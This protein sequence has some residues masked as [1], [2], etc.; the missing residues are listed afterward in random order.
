MPPTAV[1]NPLPWYRRAQAALIDWL[2]ICAL[3]VFVAAVTIGVNLLLHGTIAPEMREWQSQLV[4]FVTSVAPV[5]VGFAMLDARGGTLGKRAARLT[6][7]A[8]RAEEAGR[9]IVDGRPG[10]A[11]AVV[12]NAVKLLP[13]QLGHASTIHGIYSGYDAWAIAL[14]IAS[15]GLAIAL[16]VMAF[17][18]RDRRHLGDLLASTQVRRRC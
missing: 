4:A 11:P 16:I 13:W 6:A 9:A 18:R 8:L 17:G 2:V 14:A 1:P 5:V 3:L 10:L 15:Y 7:V 12:R